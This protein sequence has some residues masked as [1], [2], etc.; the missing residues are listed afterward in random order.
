MNNLIQTDVK[1]NSVE[2]S[3]LVEKRHDHVMRDIRNE[4]KKLGDIGQPIF[5][6]SSYINKQNKEQPC[7][8]FGKDGAMQLDLS[9]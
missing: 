3:E 4:I 5:G 8:E 6:E 2:L 7:Y 1:M 9:K